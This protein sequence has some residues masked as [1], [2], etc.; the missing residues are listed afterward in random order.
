MSDKTKPVAKIQMFP[1]SA[2]VWAKTTPKGVFYS[3][4][5]E[6]SYRDDSGKWQTTSHFNASDMLLVSKLANLVDTK[7]REL[8]AADRQA[9]H[10]DEEV[11]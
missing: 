11:A 6:R 2:A 4:S 1:L 5:L 7:V 3:V 10:L 9:G 8:R